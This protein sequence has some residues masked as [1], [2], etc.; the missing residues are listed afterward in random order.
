LQRARSAERS[1]ARDTK[2]QLGWKMGEEG[3]VLVAEPLLTSKA[4]GDAARA[5]RAA[6]ALRRVPPHATAALRSHVCAGL[7]RDAGAAPV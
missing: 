2:T 3:S 1:A 6:A 7:A 5:A 4:R